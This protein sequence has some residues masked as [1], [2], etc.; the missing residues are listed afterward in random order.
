MGLDVDTYMITKSSKVPTEGVILPEDQLYVVGYGVEV[1][2]FGDNV[3][4]LIG[5]CMSICADNREIMEGANVGD[6]NC[7]AFGCCAIWS[8]RRGRYAFTFKIGRHNTTIPQ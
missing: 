6:S 3:T 2:M 1:Y 4:D 8:S 7:G 5:S